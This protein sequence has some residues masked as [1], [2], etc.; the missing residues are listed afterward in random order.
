[1]F[2]SALPWLSLAGAAV[3]VAAGFVVF[4][5]SSIDDLGVVSSQ[6]ISQYRGLPPE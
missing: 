6:W 4:R 3:A 1:M 2:V 5:R